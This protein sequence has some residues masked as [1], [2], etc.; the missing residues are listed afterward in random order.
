MSYAFSTGGFYLETFLTFRVHSG[1]VLG[2]INKNFNISKH[3]MSFNNKKM[4]SLI[5]IM[6]F[7][8]K[9]ILFY[10]KNHNLFNL[11]IPFS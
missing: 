7:Q 11:K 2:I 8:L 1:H 5:R 4:F 6:M 10:Y 3:W 9:H